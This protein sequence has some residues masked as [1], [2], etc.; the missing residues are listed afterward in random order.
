MRLLPAIILSVAIL[1]V[2]VIWI[3]VPRLMSGDESGFAGTAI[4]SG[5]RIEIEMLSQQVEDLQIRI[6]EMARDLSQVAANAARA[7]VAPLPGQTLAPPSSGAGAEDV[8]RQNG[9]NEIIDAYA[10]VVLIADRRNVNEGLTIAGPS[11]LTRVF[12]P[13]REVMSDDCEEMTNP[14]LASKLVLEEVGPIRVRMLKPAADSLRRVFEEV[15]LTDPDLYARIDTAGSLC[16]RQI[17]GTRGRAST[18]AFG[19]AV[20]LNIDGVLDTLGDGRTQLGLTILA[21][22]FKSEGW[23]W[24]ASWGREDS[25]HF[26][27][28]RQ[29]LDEWINSGAL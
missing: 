14:R 19:L 18:H 13:P 4:D 17:R 5:A 28:S 7:P 26:E 22:F 1:L 27:V 8:F 25:M 23:V 6:D 29:K 3:F 15:R 24:G 2:P 10:Q 12:G 9:T 11:Y 20:D 21:D 16:V